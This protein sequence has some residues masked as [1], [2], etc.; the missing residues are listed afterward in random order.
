MKEAKLLWEP[1]AFGVTEAA[2]TVAGQRFDADQVAAARAELF[3]G[4][5]SCSFSEPIEDLRALGIL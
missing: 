2:F 5:G 1:S 3:V 4:H